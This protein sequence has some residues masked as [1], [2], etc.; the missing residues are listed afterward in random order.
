[1]DLSEGRVERREDSWAGIAAG[2]KRVCYGARQN[3]SIMKRQASAY[4]VLTLAIILG[5]NL[6]SASAQSTS[7][8]YVPGEIIVK[9]KGSAKTLKSQAFIG[10]SVAEKSMTLKGS[11]SGLNMHH[12]KLSS[13]AEMKQTL[14]DL[15][16]DPDVEYAE[17][18]Y[19]LRS[20]GKATAESFDD[21]Q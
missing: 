8:E 10:K 15:K 5:L 12:F 16:N 14:N 17:P 9:L 4:F 3:S 2:S 20:P 19:I 6:P 13:D 11:W 21:T 18:N 7:Q 1:M